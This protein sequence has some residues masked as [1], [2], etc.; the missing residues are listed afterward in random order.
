MCALS[1]QDGRQMRDLWIDKKLQLGRTYFLVHH[2]G[3]IFV[4]HLEP[5]MK[6]KTSRR[7]SHFSDKDPEIFVPSL[8]IGIKLKSPLP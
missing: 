3:D 1:Q 2:L 8:R 7:F 6:T 4:L 5:N